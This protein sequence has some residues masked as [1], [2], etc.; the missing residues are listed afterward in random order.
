MQRTEFLLKGFKFPSLTWKIQ[1]RSL[2]TC[3]HY[4]PDDKNIV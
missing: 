1:F 4:T 2:T 3:G